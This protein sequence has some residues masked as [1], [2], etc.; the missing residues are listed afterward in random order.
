M[1]DTQ[2][3]VSRA[4]WL[5][6]RKALLVREKAFTKQRDELSAARRALPRVRVDKDYRFTGEQGPLG[7]GDLFGDKSQLAVYHF[8]LGPDATAGCKSCT[9]WADHFS[10]IVIHLNHR[11]VAFAVISRGPLDRL[12]AYA[13]RF[14][15]TFPWVSSNGSD[16][17]FDYGVSFTAEQL[18]RGAPY[19]YGSMKA[20]NSEMPGVSVFAKD[21]DGAIF[22]TYSTYGRGIEEVNTTY[23]VLDLVPKGRDE[24][25]SQM[26]WVRRRDEYDR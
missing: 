20:P 17:N 19:N 11:D 16:F 21:P 26:A 3:I 1:V 6:A 10:P 4:E 18:E 23:S 22:H 13:K 24:G 25:D 5:E 8:M 9:F 15:W 7:L 14:G 2:R 12:Q